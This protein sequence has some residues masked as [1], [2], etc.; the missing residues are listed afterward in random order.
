M[1]RIFLVT[2]LAIVSTLC[3]AQKDK[4]LFTIGGNEKVGKAEFIQMYQKN[5]ALSST[6]I[7][8]YLDLYIN[9]RL[10]LRQAAAMG[11]D[12]DSSITKQI[13]DY[14]TSLVRPYVNDPKIFDSLSL[15]A[16][17][18]LHYLIRASHILISVPVN[19]ELKD[20]MQYYNKAKDLLN[21]LR[22]G[23]N[24][25]TL[26]KYN[27]DDSSAYYSKGTNNYGDL[28]YFTSMVM[29][30]P[31]EEAC[32]SLLDKDCNLKDSITMCHTQFGYHV[33]KITDVKK[34]SYS[35]LSLKHIFVS[36]NKHT[37][38]E[39]LSLI[40]QANDALKTLA[41]DSVAKKY[42]DDIYSAQRGGVL[43]N[44]R[45]NTLP[46]EYIDM[47]ETSKLNVP[48]APFKTRFGYHIVAFLS[49]TP[50]PSYETAR[51]NIDQRI[52]KDDRAYISTNNFVKQAKKDYNFK[53]DSVVLASVSKY[54]NDSVFSATWFIPENTNDNRTLFTL[55]KDKYSVNDFLQYVYETQTKM[56]P[57][58]L[59][60]YAYGRF[61]S[62]ADTKV[63][64]YATDRLEE[65]HPELKQA[66]DD[67]T[68][69]VLIF[70]LTD[71]QVWSKSIADTIGLQ[72]FYE[73]NKSKYN[74]TERADAT[75]WFFDTIFN[76]N[77]TLKK[78]AKLKKQG[79]S[80]T[81]VKAYFEK[82]STKKVNFSW[83]RYE[84]GSSHSID[85]YVF[86]NIDKIKN[87][88]FPQYIIDS[89]SITNKHTIIVLN[90]ILPVSTKPLSA[91]KGL[92]TSQYQEVLEQRWLNDLRQL[93]P[94]TIDYNVLK[95][96]KDE[97]K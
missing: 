66:M 21:R 94:V 26:V 58:N 14:R 86:S 85:K 53:V 50:I 11:L 44:Q 38:E 20:T 15:Q 57:I 59:S 27:S 36:S 28:G 65:K 90:D 42:S 17:D 32:F 62:F 13:R 54:M 60:A 82:K 30:Y 52:A 46:A 55:N 8:D 67:F 31:F 37:D 25:D 93:Y 3:F 49:S 75:V 18:R 87:K 83:S 79:K 70:D 64:D 56:S 24:F 78:L 71:R 33:I 69:G 40:N 22:K 16:Y 73:A 89:T 96:I 92:V 81:D 10:K 39:A 51:P 41:F 74:Y 45:P 29:I 6:S 47:F 63:L 34:V 80:D 12:K 2:I 76:V 97:I 7:D 77:K 72:N 68:A 23:E 61:E 84:K 43:L 9:Y 48:S 19:I 95:E 1:K 88:K 4:T 5:N 35:T 91:C